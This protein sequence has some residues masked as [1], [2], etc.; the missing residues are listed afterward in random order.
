MQTIGDLQTEYE[1]I[2]W[3]QMT[4]QQKQDFEEDKKREAEMWQRIFSGM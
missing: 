2:V 3:E 1:Q 4:D